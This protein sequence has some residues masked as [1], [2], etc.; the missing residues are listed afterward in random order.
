MLVLLSTNPRSRNNTPYPSSETQVPVTTA[1]L[2][3]AIP[4]NVG[5]NRSPSFA[6]AAQYVF[7]IAAICSTLTSGSGWRA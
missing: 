3:R 6:A 4:G 5:E 2:R 7:V 1:T